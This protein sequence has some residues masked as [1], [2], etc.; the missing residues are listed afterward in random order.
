MAV[1]LLLLNANS[2]SFIYLSN[3][4]TSMDTSTSS[5]HFVQSAS[6]RDYALFVKE[7][8]LRAFLSLY[9]RFLRAPTGLS[10]SSSTCHIAFENVFYTDTSVSVYRQIYKQ[11]SSFLDRHAPSWTD[12]KSL[13]T[14]KLPK[15]FNLIRINL[16][17]SRD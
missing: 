10:V 2:A 15:V 12:V 14:V 5:F 3:S 6:Y 11:L 16:P 17:I 8:S 13:P 9:A 4:S 7:A 1:S